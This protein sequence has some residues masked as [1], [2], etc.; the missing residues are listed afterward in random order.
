MHGDWLDLV[1][2]GLGV[3]FAVRGYRNGLV[4]TVAS[5]V[6]L[7]GGLWLGVT[8][9]PPLARLFTSGTAERIVAIVSVVVIAVVLQE[10][11]VGLAT[12][13]RRRMGRGTVGRAVRRV[14]A[15]TGAA[16]ALAAFLF[17][18]WVLALAVADLP[19]SALTKEVQDSVILQHI[20]QAMPATISEDFSGF[21]RVVEDRD[22]PPIFNDL[23]ITT[24]LPT[25]PPT[26][27][28]VPASVVSADAPSIVK[29]LAFEPECSQESEG[30]GFV[31]AP[32]RIVTNAHV[33]AGARQV[34]IVQNGAGQ[35][36][37]EAATVVYYNPDVDVA[38]L[39]VP[40]LGLP[41]LH[42][43]GPQ[44]AGANAEVVGYPENGPFTPVPARIRETETV[45]GPNIY[46]D[47]QVTRQI[48][49]LRAVVEP[50]NS[51]GPLLDPQGQVDGIVFARE[52]GSS[53]TGFALTA[54]EVAPEVAAGE[55][56]S[57]PVSTQGCI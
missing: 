7:V 30:S 18:L 10:V 13:V 27:G 56:A 45:T 29:I 5:I 8:V 49:A 32:G 4:V 35:V 36:I 37:D 26:P 2:L 57:T 38:V 43:A 9:A 44:P 53:D 34:R 6:G 16:G 3:L 23:G 12:A 52:V 21:L 48:Y 47:A 50:G 33:V 42:F 51:G 19:P 54:H 39:A 14:D 24:V 46:Q 41:A 28:A 15:I 20:D 17:V 40:G 22:F 1:I 11:A 31:V 55:A 25:P